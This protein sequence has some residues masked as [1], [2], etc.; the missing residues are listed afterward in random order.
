MTPR[1]NTTLNQSTLEDEGGEDFYIDV[2]S[3]Q[4]KYI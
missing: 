3:L 2:D 1:S 4:V